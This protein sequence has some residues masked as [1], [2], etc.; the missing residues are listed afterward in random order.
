[1]FYILFVIKEKEYFCLKISTN[2]VE[3]CTFVIQKTNT[4]YQKTITK[5]VK[6]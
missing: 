1:M 5:S 3:D 6:I 4:K 2:E